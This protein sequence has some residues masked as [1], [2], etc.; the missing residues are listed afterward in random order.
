MYAARILVLALLFACLVTSAVMARNVIF[1]GTGLV[2]KSSFLINKP[3]EGVVSVVFDA[4]ND[5]AVRLGYKVV[6]PDGNE[7]K[8]AL[9]L[10]DADVYR[11]EGGSRSEAKL[12]VHSG[13]YHR[14][15]GFAG[16]SGTWFEADAGDD[17]GFRVKFTRDDGATLNLN[18]VSKEQPST[19]G[20]T[21]PDMAFT[22][23]VNDLSNPDVRDG[24]VFN[25]VIQ[26]RLDFNALMR[27]D[28]TSAEALLE[29]LF[30]N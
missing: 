20:D 12:L 21:I 17:I 10:N 15:D 19:M 28:D 16:T 1:R 14:V 3:V 2:S 22:I 9:V 30:G 13:D 5:K 18:I 6:F 23:N 11:E 26:S 7:E 24:I 25:W 8:L 27:V 4:T 29:E